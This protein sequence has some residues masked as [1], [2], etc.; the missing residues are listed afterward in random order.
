MEPM[1]SE[2]QDFMKV[3][4]TPQLSL[5]RK[6]RRQGRAGVFQKLRRHLSMVN[7]AVKKA[8]EWVLEGGGDNS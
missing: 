5:I 6:G 4:A 1:G 2:E 8:A 3:D 7:A